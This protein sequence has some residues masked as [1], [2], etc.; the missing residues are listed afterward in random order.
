MDA[1]MD[2]SKAM[3][4]SHQVSKLELATILIGTFCVLALSIW[5][6]SLFAPITFL[7]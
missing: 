5:I 7:H 3:E 6:T 1:K 2:M 4:N